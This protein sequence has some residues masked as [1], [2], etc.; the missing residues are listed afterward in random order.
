MTTIISLDGGLGRI[1][2]AIPALLKYHKNHPDEEWYIT[3]PGWDFIM[4][5]FPEL[6]ERTFNP[7]ARGSFDLFWKA[8]RVITAEPYRVPAYYRNEISL[9][10]AFDVVINDS[11]DHSDLP[12]MQLRLS[13][14]EKRKAFE[15]IEQ[16]KKM[17]KKEK[18]IVLQ[19][20]GSTA[21][22]HSSGIFDDSLRSMPMNMI[23]Y[24]I[25]NL[26]NHYNLIFMGAKEF[27]NIKTYKPDPDPNLREWAAI[28][29][30]A[31]YF[32]GCD[33]C[34]Q[35]MCRALNKPASVMIAG[36]HPINITYDNFHI[37]ERDVT[38]YP[39]AMRISG[40][41]SHMSSRLN[42]PRIEFTQEEIEKAYQ[43]IIEKIEGKIVKDK[44]EVKKP[45]EI[46]GVLYN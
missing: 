23:D 31:D 20:F 7:D 43:E 45:K 9:R 32:I 34:G 2:T 12:Q 11:A 21:T 24:F 10:E 25:K 30:A 17:H 8:D 18:T 4:W 33:S 42:E 46:K 38:F 39:D 28:I 29:G 6:Q 13:F 1:I 3:I 5:G 44:I 14:P 22:P 36:T 27:H 41:Q 35:H 37:I 15:V 19:P 26:S 16:A 40:F